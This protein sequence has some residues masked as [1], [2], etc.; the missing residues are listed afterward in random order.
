MHQTRG[1][2]PSLNGNL[3]EKSHKDP[4]THPGSQKWLCITRELELKTF[5]K[6]YLKL[7]VIIHPRFSISAFFFDCFKYA[8]ELFRGNSGDANN[9]S[10][11]IRKSQWTL[12]LELVN[13]TDSINLNSIVQPWSRD[14]L[15]DMISSK[16]TPKNADEHILNFK[17]WR[18]TSNSL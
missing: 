10:V 11:E 16:K 8:T 7:R 4:N 14:I 2:Y 1:W 18:I 6:H 3:T 17:H 13:R 5:Q 9:F 15:Y 12:I